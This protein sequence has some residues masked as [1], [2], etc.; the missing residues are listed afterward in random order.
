M[1]HT[2]ALLLFV[3]FVD[4][5]PAEGDWDVEEE[6]PRCPTGVDGDCLAAPPLWTCAVFPLAKDAE[7]PVLLFATAGEDDDPPRPVTTT[8]SSCAIADVFFAATQPI[9]SM[10]SLFHSNAGLSCRCLSL[11]PPQSRQQTIDITAWSTYRGAA[12]LPVHGCNVATPGVRAP[13]LHATVALEALWNS[14]LVSCAISD[15]L[16]T[17]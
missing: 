10:T 11:T 14:F 15:V 2:T 7:R 16:P 8:A 9:F 3:V 1:G 17:F 5:P 13:Y 6:A 12:G 4:T